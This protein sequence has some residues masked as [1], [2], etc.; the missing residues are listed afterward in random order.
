[1]NK[2]FLFLLILISVSGCLNTY[3][4]PNFVQD[5]EITTDVNNVTTNDLNSPQFGFP[6]LA[7]I[8][9]DGT[10]NL[11]F[12][13]VNQPA[14]ILLRDLNASVTGG[15]GGG[16]DANGN[17][18]GVVNQL[19]IFSDGNT[20]YSDANFTRNP[21]NNNVDI[22]GGSLRIR[23]Q[24]QQQNN[25]G[26]IIDTFNTI[27][28]GFI[29]QTVRFT[30]FSDDQVNVN[31]SFIFN[32]ARTGTESGGHVPYRFQ[33]NGSD[34][35][36][37]GYQGAIN[38][39]NDV[40][41]IGAVRHRNSGGNL[42]VYVGQEGNTS[43]NS[44]GIWANTISAGTQVMGMFWTGSNVFFPQGKMIIGDTNYNSPIELDVRG[45]GDINGLEYC[46]YGDCIDAWGMTQ[47]LYVRKGDDSGQC[48]MDINKGVVTA[49]DCI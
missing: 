36:V 37:I 23:T 28:G 44:G 46:I 29:G 31:G 18:S 17:A 5:L 30:N 14:C 39:F 16:T 2:I 45:T 26:L 40:S 27:V 47:T 43:N 4:S 15:G 9:E 35:F 7:R 21:N 1:M 24:G 41:V 25:N 12:C 13:D 19:G 11:Q 22:N 32:A 48:F 10:G 20:L 34:I 3:S 42:N 33:V 8:T 38:F 49:S 6:L